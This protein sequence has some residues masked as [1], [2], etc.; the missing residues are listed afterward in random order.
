MR[1]QT[2]S[3]RRDK[4]TALRACGSRAASSGRNFRAT[5]RPRR[6]SSALYTTPMPPPPSF[7][8]M[9]VVRDRRVDHD[10]RLLKGCLIIGRKELSVNSGLI[11]LGLSPSSPRS[12]D[13]S[14]IR[15][16]ISALRSCGCIHGVAPICWHG[17]PDPAAF[18]LC[19]HPLFAPPSL[20]FSAKFMLGPGKLS[21]KPSWP[22]I[23]LC[24]SF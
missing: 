10:D 17:V 5:N 9:P 21:P 11:S 8:P 13:M 7:S 3:R 24:C 1:I 20:P 12:F 18:R 15:P 14:S 23:S 22:L 6:A 19:C 2:G 4:A 16:P